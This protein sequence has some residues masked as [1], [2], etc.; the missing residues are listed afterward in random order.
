MPTGVASLTATAGQDNRCYQQGKNQTQ[1][2]NSSL[3]AV[4]KSLVW[5]Q[6]GFPNP[7]C[8]TQN[9]PVLHHNNTLLVCISQKNKYVEG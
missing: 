7:V 2:T 4:F 3:L 6:F 8:I 9:L 1:S 5:F